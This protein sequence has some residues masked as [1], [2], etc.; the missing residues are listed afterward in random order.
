MATWRGY[1]GKQLS[2]KLCLGSHF[3]LRSLVKHGRLTGLQDHP[4]PCSRNSHIPW[5]VL[6]AASP[7]S[8]H[9]PE[10]LAGQGGSEEKLIAE[11]SQD[12]DMHTSLPCIAHRFPSEPRI[13][14]ASCQTFLG[15]VQSDITQAVL[16]EPPSTTFMQESPHVRACRGEVWAR[17]YPSWFLASAL[18]KS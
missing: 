7:P 13:L 16:A 3:C 6:R 8:L 11:R 2:S 9:V 14:I 12:C 15:G 10:I 4:S 18:C 17:F 5:A 1:F